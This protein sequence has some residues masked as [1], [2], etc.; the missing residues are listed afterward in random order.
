M[1][2][3]FV[4]RSMIGK[5][6][7]LAATLAQAQVCTPVEVHNVRPGEGRLM[8][9]AYD[10]AAD[11]SSKALAA[12]VQ[13]RADAEQLSFQVCGLKGAVVSLSAFQDLNSNG[14][15]DANA[16]GMPSEPWGA[17]G[18][19][20]NFGP[21]TWDATQVPVDGKPIVVKLSK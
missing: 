9:V 3:A 14:K 4:L 12:A 5:S 15:L 6:L 17:S 2:Y 13:L 21:P 20:S 1:K 18:K 19:P 11:F 16:M 8:L 7:L 10:S